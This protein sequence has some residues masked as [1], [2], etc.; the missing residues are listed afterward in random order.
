[1]QNRKMPTSR[2]SGS[3]TDSARRP[4]PDGLQCVVHEV[5]ILDQRVGIEIPRALGGRP[6]FSSVREGGFDARQHAAHELA[7]NFPAIAGLARLTVGE[8]AKSVRHGVSERRRA[9]AAPAPGY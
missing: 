2:R 8:R 4:A 9:A 6:L 1:M 5:D 3:N 7:K